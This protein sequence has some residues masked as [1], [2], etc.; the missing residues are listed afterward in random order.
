MTTKELVRAEIERQM[1]FYDDKEREVLDEPEQFTYALFYQGHQ[2]MC[3]KLLSFLD[4][5]PDEPVSDCHD[6]EDEICEYMS[7]E[8]NNPFDWD[9]RD[10]RDYAIHFAQ[11]GA[12]HLR[13]TT[14]K[15]SEDLEEAAEEY[16]TTHLR[17]N[18][19]PTADSAFKAG[20]EWQKAKILKDN[21]VI[22]PVEDFQALIDSH[23]KRVEA[24]Y[25]EKMLKEAVEGYVNYY[26]DSG[27]ILMAEAQV[28]CPYHNGDKV[29]IIIVKE[30]KK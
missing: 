11:W 10:K 29:K 19:F 21:P 1:K 25:K 20:A 12:E 22:M 7:N 28:G 6:L 15:I 30:D 4:T 14:K 13:D 18:E 27:G 3:A 17:N 24:D 5:L 26:E 23:A 8:D 9:W 2:K 16:A